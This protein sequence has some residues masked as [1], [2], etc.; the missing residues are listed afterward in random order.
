MSLLR[1][2]VMLSDMLPCA[3]AHGEAIS[4]LRG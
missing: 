4:P 2:F 1:S 3:R